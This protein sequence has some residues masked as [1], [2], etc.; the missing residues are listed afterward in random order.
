MSVP[1][2]EVRTYYGQP[3]LKPPEWTWEVPWYLL[4]GGMGGAASELGAC[5]RLLGDDAL[6][7]RALDVAMF[8]AV[9]SPVLLVK[10]LGRPSRFLN[11]LRVFKPTSAMSM[12]SWLLSGYGASVTAARAMRGLALPP[13][14]RAGVEMLSGVLGLGMS[15]YTAVLVADSSVPVW[16][17]ARGFLPFVFASSSAASAGAV[18]TVLVDP[19]QAGPARRLAIGGAVAELAATH[20]MESDLGEIGEVYEHGMPGRLAKAA[21][22]CTALGAA[23]LAVGGRARS[24]GRR[25]AGIA[26]ASLLLVGSA[27][28][29]WSVF[30][31][32]FAS[33]GDPRYVVGPQR[34]RRDADSV[35]R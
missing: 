8:S 16:H 34:D 27:L 11:M 22:G 6:A 29:R 14:L 3:V 20:R 4:I 13:R 35:P 10:D 9:A 18:L 28:Q 26:G 24:G 25:S 23:L 12:G 2:Q 7:D 15:T 5:A 17:E 32:G 33:A 31:A 19:A 30:K 21:K 1:D